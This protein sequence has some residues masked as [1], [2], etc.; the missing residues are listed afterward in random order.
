MARARTVFRCQSCGAA[1]PKWA[2]RC[3]TCEE[4][5]T[6]QEEL[7]APVAHAEVPVALTEHAVPIGDVVMEGFTANST[8]VSEFDRVLGGG[9][10]PGSVTLLGGEPGIGKSTLLLQVAAAVAEGGST[11]LYVSAEESAQQVRLRAE[12]LGALQPGLLV[13]AE[14]SVPAIAAHVHEAAPSLL[15]VDSIQTVHDPA[16]GS[17]PGSVTQVRESAARLV[18]IAKSRGMACVLVGHVTKDGALAGPRV[19]EHLVDTVL[20]FE[21]DRHHVLRLLRA[22]KHRFGPTAELGVLEMGTAGLLPVADPSGML[23]ADRRAGVSGSVVVPCIEGRRPLLVEV[24]ALVGPSSLATP[25]RSVTGLEGNRVAM[26]LAVLT[27]RLGVSVATSD[28]YALAVGGVRATEPAA[29]LGIA[30]AV[31][32]SVID[33]PLPE[34]LVVIGEVGLTGEVR[35]VTSVDQRLREAQRLGFTRA[36]VPFTSPS[37]PPGIAV[38]RAATVA[39]ALRLLE[40]G[41]S[42]SPFA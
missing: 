27:Q 16:L 29:D 18:A 34:D 5:N 26:I 33:V 39:D 1:A 37:P 19:L 31:V 24:Q 35:Q 7:E 23:L 10:V 42:A 6:L 25:R 9:L 41:P 2:G 28:V 13:V 30:F 12:R 21:G 14:A 8:G 3:P 32:S 11:V 40:A 20:A 38:E 15:I 17:A 36:I 4:W 22:V